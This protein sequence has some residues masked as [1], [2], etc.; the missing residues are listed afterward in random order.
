MANYEGKARS[1]YFHVDDKQKFL[2]WMSNHSGAADSIK[3]VY[4]PETENSEIG[5][6][7]LMENSP[8]PYDIG[9]LESHM[10]YDYH[11][12][13][14]DTFALL[15]DGGLMDDSETWDE[16]GHDFLHALQP[17]IQDD[18]ACIITEVGWEKFRY[19]AA[20]A[21]VITKDVLRHVDLGRKAVDTARQII[22]KDWTT[23]FEY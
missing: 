12:D 13:A 16:E 18:D 15:F 10:E 7:E 19:L 23:V 9:F 8:Y 14:K 2:S 17:F 1:N 21:F 3:I 20:D 5:A 11:E 22:G 4:S 6:I